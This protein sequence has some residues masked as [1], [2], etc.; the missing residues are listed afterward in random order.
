MKA[1]SVGIDPTT[2][3]QIT[4]IPPE[5][6]RAF[7]HE[8]FT[9][10]PS[11]RRASEIDAGDQLQYI[12]ALAVEL[13]RAIDDGRDIPL[14]SGASLERGLRMIAHCGAVEAFLAYKPNDPDQALVLTDFWVGIVAI[15]APDKKAPAIPTRDH[16]ISGYYFGPK[17]SVDA[18]INLRIAFDE[19]SRGDTEAYRVL[20]LNISAAA[21][22]LK[23][24][25]AERGVAGAL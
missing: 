12:D 23:R 20:H 5:Q 11:L 8:A 21:R 16:R 14:D 13:A 2:F 25:A 22:R 1:E 18:E 24:R 15:S 6:Q 3:F 7:A 19:A 4:G 17:P 9:L 10:W